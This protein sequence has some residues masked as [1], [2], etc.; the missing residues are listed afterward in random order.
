MTD[1]EKVEKAPYFLE[2]RKGKYRTSYRVIWRGEGLDIRETLKGSF[3]NWREAAAAA[4]KIIAEQRFGKQKPVAEY[5]LSETL[6]DEIVELK[7]SKDPAT[8][9]QAELFFRLHL[10]PFLA[11]H[12]PYATELNATTWLKYKNWMRLKN[13]KVALFNHWKFFVQLAKYAFEKGLI[14]AKLK[15]EYSE[16]RE[17]FRERGLVIPD[18]DFWK[19]VEAATP[20]HFGKLERVQP[21]WRDRI[22]IQR[23]TGMRPGEVRDLLKDRWDTEAKVISLR[24][25]DTKTRQP[26]SFVV[27]SELVIEILDRRL[28]RVEGPYFFPSEACEAKPMAKSLNGWNAILKRAGVS[29]DFTPH[30]LRHSYLTGMFKTSSNPALICYQAGLSLE[31]AQKTYLHFTAADTRAI[32]QEAA[33]SGGR[34]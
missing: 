34:E 9:A 12:C 26:R 15:L 18:A 11:E 7:K 19:M 3:R 28:K 21:K 31:E 1:W 8:Y 22:L 5:V 14:P 17:D 30:D 27:E 23:F 4:E 16:Q 25:E 33:K 6:C 24:K 10:K 13:P 20:K 2:V 29:A 32:A